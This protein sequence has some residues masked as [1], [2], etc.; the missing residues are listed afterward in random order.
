MKRLCL[1]FCIYL[2]VI[3][4]MCTGFQAEEYKIFVVIIAVIFFLYWSV[5]SSD[6]F[7]NNR[8]LRWIQYV[9]YFGLASY[10][11][12]EGEQFLRGGKVLG[13]AVL[14]IVNTTFHRDFIYFINVNENT[15]RSDMIIFIVITLLLYSGILLLSRRKCI[16]IICFTMPVMIFTLIFAPKA[17][18][19]DFFLYFAGILGLY[20]LEH[21]KLKC[22]S[23]GFCVIALL[24][25][26]FEVYP[27][28]EL[29]GQEMNSIRQG[30]LVLF[31]YA[32]NVIGGK[33]SVFTLNF[34]DLKQE[35]TQQYDT[36][37]KLQITMDYVEDIVYL[38]SYVG[39][40]YS[41][42]KW[43]QDNEEMKKE[44]H[45]FPLW[46][47]R[48]LETLDDKIAKILKPTVRNM[49]IES[50][51]ENESTNFEPYY[52]TQT[53]NGKITYLAVQDLDA[54][55]SVEIPEYDA[56]LPAQYY[57]AEQE[58]ENR[59]RKTS[60]D[61]PDH[62]EEEL[63]NIRKEYYE[64]DDSLAERVAK[65]KKYLRENYTYTSNVGNIPE[66]SDPTIYFLKDSK[67]GYCS[68][69]ASAAV[70]MFRSC[71]TPA[72]YAEGYVLKEDDLKDASVTDGKMVFRLQEKDA[73]AWVEIYVDGIGWVP[74]DVAPEHLLVAASDAREIDL[75]N[76][77]KITKSMNELILDGMRILL[78]FCCLILLRIVCIHGIYHYQKKK[79][80]RKERIQSYAIV[81]E[82]YCDGGNQEEI[83]CIIERARYSNHEMT[84][85]EEMLVYKA[86]LATRNQYRQKLPVYI[87]L[88]DMCIICRDIL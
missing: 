1:L 10:V 60:L 74:V 69:Y 68:Q 73:Y 24:G 80:T 18:H 19:G 61:I 20:Y 43:I 59:A 88:F 34:G 58:E 2:S 5:L 72:R 9:Q 67:K 39:N 17:V 76:L 12:Y 62:L 78:C 48:V 53:K 41:F 55:L 50:L 77:P 23:I 52:T 85:E 6:L 70:M 32:N 26:I 29:F 86:A 54:L 13:N 71:G 36:G 33:R 31:E 30:T 16:L 14:E 79:M 37:A 87:N 65:I 47:Y 63:Q 64:Y 51:S 75:P 27:S 42:G 57:A 25:I 38:R 66:G 21:H 46:K 49:E 8:L 7:H 11:L 83:K 84:K 40:Q 45:S 22:A 44:D 28:S 15:A 4:G 56:D 82:R 81:W 3:Y 35:A